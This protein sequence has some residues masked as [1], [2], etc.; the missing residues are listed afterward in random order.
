MSR[1]KSTLF[2]LA[3]LCPLTACETPEDEVET[4][5][6]ENFTDGMAVDSDQ[7]AFRV[8][9]WSD[10]GDLEAGR[11]DLIMRIG[12]HD[13]EDPEDPGL[14]IPGARIDLDAWMPNANEAMPS[15]PVVSYMGDGAY[16]IENVVL[17][18]DGVWNFDFEVVVGENMHETVSLAFAVE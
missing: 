15:E 1:I 18:D 5:A 7:G 2:A 3:I 12:F 8:I 6:I 16:L 17:P 13:P 11:N 10:D 4:R 9:L 14:G